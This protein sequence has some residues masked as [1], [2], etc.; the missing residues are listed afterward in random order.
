MKG[1]PP[2]RLLLCTG[3]R[4]NADGKALALLSCLQV[5]LEA[6]HRGDKAFFL[7][8]SCLGRCTGKPIARIDPD[9]I[10]YHRLSVENLQRIVRQHLCRGLPVKDLQ[11]LNAENNPD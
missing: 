11:L 5:Q 7:R 4:C 6:S 10:W 2:R 3:P 8:R 9:G 1:K